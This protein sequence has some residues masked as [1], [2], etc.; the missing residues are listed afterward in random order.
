MSHYR[1]YALHR[2]GGF[3]SGASLE[4]DCDEDALGQVTE[5]VGWMTRAEVW[6]GTRLVASIPF[7]L[8]VHVPQAFVGEALAS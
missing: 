8:P 6:C 4:C 5:V 1:I 2:D 3:Q 7:P